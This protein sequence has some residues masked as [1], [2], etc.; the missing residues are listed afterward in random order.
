MKDKT[1]TVR[2]PDFCPE[3][4]PEFEIHDERFEFRTIDE[5]LRF[6]QETRYNC[7]HE[8]LC[9]MLHNQI[10]KEEIKDS[11]PGDC[12]HGWHRCPYCGEGF[13]ATG[14]TLYKTKHGNLYECKKCG[15]KMRVR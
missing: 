9:R 1:I 15:K 4:C 6:E 11:L 7:E 3:D 13:E 2:V 5:G 10:Q 12:F 14:V 8:G